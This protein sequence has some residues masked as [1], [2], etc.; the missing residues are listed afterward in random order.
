[1]SFAGNVT[2]KKADDLRAAARLV[3]ED[4]LLVETDSPYLAPVPMRGKPNRPAY[5][6]YTL[7]AIA[8]IRGTD[9]EELART[10]TANAHRVF[11]W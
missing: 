3:P 11:G 7:E 2:F 6:R 10:T 8:E 5:V 9:P 1:V 4:H